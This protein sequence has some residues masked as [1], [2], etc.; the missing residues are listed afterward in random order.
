MILA[1]L[2]SA[3]AVAAGVPAWVAPVV[4]PADVV[5]QYRDHARSKGRSGADAT[6]AC[7]NFAEELLLC[8]RWKD[9]ERI[10]RLTD[11][12]LTRMGVGLVEIEAQAT[13]LSELAVTAAR[14]T[15]RTVPDVEGSYFVSEVG[16]GMDAAPFLAPM[17][18]EQVLGARPVLACPADGGVIAWVPG[19]ADL[20]KIVAVGV[21]KAHD[22]ASHPVSPRVYVWDGAGWVVWGEAVAAPAP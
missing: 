12:D 7:R 19:Q 17:A 2:L 5:S 9:G 21:R 11:A 15:Q 18:L 22:S 10:A 3:A 6:L 4:E 20:D 14:F 1:C 13:R 16:D 8:F